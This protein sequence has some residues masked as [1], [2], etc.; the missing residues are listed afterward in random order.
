CISKGNVTANTSKSQVICGG[1]VGQNGGEIKDCHVNDEAPDKDKYIGVTGGEYIGGFCGYNRES[2]EIKGCASKNCN[3]KS[4]TWLSS[5]CCGGFV[6]KNRGTITCTKDDKGNI[7]KCEFSGAVNGCIDT[8]KLL[9]IGVSSAVAAALVV[10]VIYYLIARYNSKS[11]NNHTND[12]SSTM[13]E[14]DI[15]NYHNNLDDPINISL[16]NEGEQ[17]I[18]KVNSRYRGALKSFKKSEILKTITLTTIVACIASVATGVVIEETAKNAYVGGFCGYNVNKINNSIS[19]SKV[20]AKSLY[21]KYNRCGGFVGTNEGVLEN[22]EAYGKKI[23]FKMHAGGYLGGFVGENISNIY[24]CESLMNVKN[25]K[26][27]GG[28]CGYNEGGILKSNSCGSA[29]TNAKTSTN[30]TRCGGFVG[31]HKKGMING[32]ESNGNATGNEYV[33][34]FCGDNVAKIMNCKST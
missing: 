17:I 32:C 8:E 7:D 23:E 6:G 26:C 34:G 4:S 5:I 18:K 2:A 12:G 25:G 15:M 27:T 22:C 9:A 10:G 29:E 28:F 19:E 11:I 3:V 30:T 13:D 14:R 24:N 31:Y 21:N 16:L 1:F 33:G 20:E